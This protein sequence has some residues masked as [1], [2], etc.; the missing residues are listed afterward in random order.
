MPEEKKLDFTDPSFMTAGIFAFVGDLFSLGLLA[1]AI[2][3]VGIVIAVFCLLIRYFVAALA[4]AFV[5]PRLKH[6][7][8][9]LAFIIAAL[10]PLPTLM[11]GL[12]IAFVLQNKFIEQM[13]VTA[14]AALVTGP[15]APLAVSAGKAAPAA[16]TAT[17]AAKAVPETAKIGIFAAWTLEGGA[18]A[19]EKTAARLPEVKAPKPKKNGRFGQSTKERKEAEKGEYD[20]FSE[21]GDGNEEDREES[22]GVDG[23]YDVFGNSINLRS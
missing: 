19:A 12:V 10:L 18:E 4:A 2:P 13:V 7:I 14:A 11:I 1:L 23:S 16:K 22:E 8:P 5:V 17:T 3:A 9:R 15:A 21:S 6:F 20:Y